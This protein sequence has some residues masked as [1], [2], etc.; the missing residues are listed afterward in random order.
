VHILEVPLQDEQE[1]AIALA[2]LERLYALRGDTGDAGRWGHFAVLARGWSDLDALHTLCRQRGIPVRRMNQKPPIPLHSS[3]EGASLLK[4]LRG[5]GRRPVRRRVVLCTSALGRWLR[6]HGPL[7]GETADNP[8]LAALTQFIAE[9]Q[10]AAPGGEVVADDLI[11]DL[12]AFDFTAQKAGTP[13][14]NAP[15]QLMV[16]HSAKGLEF[17]HVLILDTGGWSARDDDERRL[18]YVAMTRAR[19]TLTLCE[20]VGQRHPFMSDLQ[21]LALRTR[22][23]PPTA[24]PAPIH[25]TCMQ[26]YTPQD[27]YLSWAGRLPP[28]AP[29]HQAIAALSVATH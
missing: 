23:T 27:V 24:L 6:R 18:F 19:Q 16:A 22:P 28:S 11:D 13:P 1:A 25:R 29:Q 2:E 3:R 8:F 26:S 12:Y 17:D 4:L 20:R 14:P 15:L 10:A 7:P 21:A 9:T 5:E